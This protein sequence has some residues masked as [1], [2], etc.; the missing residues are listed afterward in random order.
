MYRRFFFCFRTSNVHP[1]LNEND[2]F[3]VH[4]L[5]SYKSKED[6]PMANKI[7][8]ETLRALYRTHISLFSSHN[9]LSNVEDDLLMLLMVTVVEQQ[10]PVYDDHSYA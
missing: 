2:K 8:I 1:Y 6:D 9:L 5:C 10:T 3:V 4:S 7:I